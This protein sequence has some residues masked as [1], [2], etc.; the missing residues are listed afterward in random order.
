LC[1]GFER[2]TPH[3][4]FVIVRDPVF[5]IPLHETRKYDLVTWNGSQSEIHSDSKYVTN[6]TILLSAIE[7]KTE[8]AKDISFLLNDSA[9]LHGRVM[10]SMRQELKVTSPFLA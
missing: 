7:G 3:G 9:V 10:G 4:L 6:S 1:P 8:R 5:R 2:V